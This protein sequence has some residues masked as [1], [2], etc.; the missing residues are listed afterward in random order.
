MNSAN[1]ADEGLVCV[2]RCATQNNWLKHYE[3][4][5]LKEAEK[6]CSP[7]NKQ[8]CALAEELRGLNASR[9]AEYAAYATK[10]RAEAKEKGITLSL[11][12]F[13]RQTITP[14]QETAIRK[15]I[16]VQSNGVIKPES[17]DFMR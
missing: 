15:A 5:Q 8:A 11:E 4:E 16:S 12:E 10:V 17:I 14:Q 1:D 2:V 7:A 13:D 9:D 3:A 6:A